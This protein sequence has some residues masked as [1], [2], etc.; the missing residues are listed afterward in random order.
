MG[1]HYLLRYC[2]IVIHNSLI[3]FHMS[4]LSGVAFSFFISNF[5]DLILLSFFLDESG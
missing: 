3:I 5:G 4:A 2:H 1:L